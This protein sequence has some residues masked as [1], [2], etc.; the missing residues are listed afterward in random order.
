MNKQNFAYV[1]SKIRMW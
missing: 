1:S